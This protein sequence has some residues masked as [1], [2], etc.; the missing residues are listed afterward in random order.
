ML[1]SDWVTRRKTNHIDN[2]LGIA[3]KK[4]GIF[5]VTIMLN[6]EVISLGKSAQIKGGFKNYPKSF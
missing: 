3:S 2:F 4:F 5:S 6:V 1:I